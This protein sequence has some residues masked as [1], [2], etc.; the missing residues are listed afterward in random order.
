MNPEPNGSAP[1]RLPDASA[2][3]A[4]L[5]REDLP[6]LR[7]AAEAL[8]MAFFSVDLSRARN[9]PGFIRAFSRDLHFPEWFGGNLDAL[10]DCLTDLSWHPAPGYVI[11]LEGSDT[12][13]ANPTSFATLNA[14]LAHV[15]ESWKT[16]STPFWIFYITADKAETPVTS[17][18]GRG[19]S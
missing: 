16:R 4:K 9:V 5:A 3:L 12:L 13:S 2:G 10:H 7:Q 17:V 11:T 19:D 1:N 8:N 15:V 18:P 14:V 6:G